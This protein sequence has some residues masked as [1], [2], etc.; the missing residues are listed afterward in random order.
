MNVERDVVELVFQARWTCLRCLIARLEGAGLRHRGVRSRC[1]SA[2][3]PCCKGPGPSAAEHAGRRPRGA[4]RPG[5]RD[6]QRRCRNLGVRAAER[7]PRRRRPPTVSPAWKTGNPRPQL[8]P[9]FI[10]EMGIS[11][12]QLNETLL[13]LEQGSSHEAIETLMCVCHRIKGSAASLE[14]SRAAKLAHLMED[15][16][17]QL[18]DARGTLCPAT[19]DA[20]LACSDGLRQYVEGLKQGQAD[21]A[22]LGRFA[23]ELLLAGQAAGKQSEARPEAVSP[24]LHALVAAA[25]G[26]SDAVLVGEVSFQPGLPLAGLKGRLIYEKLAAAGEVCYFQPPPA[27]LDGWRPRADRL[28]RRHA[29]APG[30]LRRPVADFRRPTRGPGAAGGRAGRAWARGGRHAA[31]IRAGP[32]LPAE[33]SGRTRADRRGSGR[34]EPRRRQCQADGDLA[35]RHRAAGPIDEPGRP[36]GDQQGP[37]RPDR[38]ASPTAPW[39]ARSRC[40]SSAGP[41]HAG[42]D[43]RRG[44]G[45]RARS[46]GSGDAAALCRQARRLRHELESVRHDLQLLGEARSSLGDLFETIHQLDRISDGIQQG[47]MSTRMLPIGPLFGRFKRVIRDITRANGKRHSPGNQRREDGIGQADDRRAGRPA[48]PP[49]AQRGRPR[50]RVARGAGGGGEAPAGHDHPGRLP[51]RQSDHR[52]GPRR[53]RRVGCRAASAA[54][55]SSAA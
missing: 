17:Q 14:L 30:D 36:T 49:G 6:G 32:R 12:D 55:P 44:R 18:L 42:E 54:R 24:Q 15:L 50:H 40:R 1:W 2:S 26:D 46:G 31:A 10:D 27:Q 16:L 43:G 52:P 21:S 53:R 4:G 41:R 22:A 48:D 39:A 20:L 34:K 9:I 3:R 35:G 13:A 11:L 33:D 47:V 7:C 19:I 5:S 8:L 38:P 45:A 28:R 23:A 51:L 37:L 29:G 25:A